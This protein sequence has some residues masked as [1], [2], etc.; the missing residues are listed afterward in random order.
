MGNKISLEGIF[1]EFGWNYNEVRE[2]AERLGLV[3]E[4]FR[5]DNIDCETEDSYF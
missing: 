3:A 5:L 2:A 1:F 4:L